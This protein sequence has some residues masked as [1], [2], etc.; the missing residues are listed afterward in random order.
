[1][2]RI[3]VLDANVLWPQYLRDA[4]LSAA[5]F[6]LYQGHWTEQ[7]LEEMR[8]S[9]LRKGRKTQERANWTLEEMRRGFPHFMVS[10]H[11]FLIP[12]MTNHEKDRHVLAA[13]VHAGADTIVT[14][15]QKDFPPASREP[16]CIEL[17]TPDEFLMDL[18][19]GSTHRMARA[20]VKMAGRL[21][22]PPY[23]VQELVGD[24][25]CRQAPTF[26]EQALA[27]GELETAVQAE[28]DGVPLPQF[29][30]F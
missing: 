5:S 8:A 16:H 4:L 2:A 13:A 26:A 9:I 21:K 18:W 30:L 15:N 24:I 6:D 3:A 19:V 14:F 1:M 10:G 12:L 20:L 17:D 27:S 11:E 25:L 29:R 28:Q 23:T 7:I 22:K